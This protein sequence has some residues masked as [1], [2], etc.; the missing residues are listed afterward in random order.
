MDVYKSSIIRQQLDDRE[1][2]AL[3]ADFIQ[4]KSSH[5]VPD[6]F[7]RDVLYDHPNTLP[8]LKAEEVWHLHLADPDAPW[9]RRKIQFY[10]TSDIHLVYCRAALQADTY[11]LMAILKPDAHAQARNNAIMLRLGMMAELFRRK[12]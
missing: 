6:L 9:D 3:E 8:V 7:G 12:F 4:Y 1:L 10:K 5:T 2:A 11:L